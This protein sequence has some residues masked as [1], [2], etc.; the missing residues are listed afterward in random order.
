MLPA[1]AAGFSAPLTA[2]DGEVRVSAS[3]GPQGQVVALWA[4]EE[5]HSALTAATQRPGFATFP[6]PGAS[7]VVAVRVS[8]HDPGPV[9]A[10]R[11]PSMG[12]AHVTVQPLPSGRF[13][14]VAARSQWRHDGPDRN[15]IIYD[16]DGRVLDEA[17]LG[18]GIEH[19]LATSDGY[20]WAGYFDEGVYGNYGW[21]NPDAEPPVGWPG[22]VRFTPGLQADWRFPSHV[23]QP[24]GAI[25]DCYALNVDDSAVWACYYTDWPIVRI[26]ADQVTSWP[27]AVAGARA[28]AVSGDQVALFGGYGADHDRLIVGHLGSAGFE[29]SHE[30][31]VVLP[32]GAP[33]P[34]RTQVIGR[35]PCLHFLTADSWYQLTVTSIQPA[36]AG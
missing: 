31:R 4:A 27:N 14:V 34:A 22:L 1:V 15:A 11:I 12:L 35:G 10:A 7:R 30:Y 2:A 3:V 20:V 33:V 9:T 21:G 32:G 23:E 29:V 36:G 24:W 6:D 26:E 25:S 19:V 13:L 28:L 17:V 5:D 16:S 18:D 8:V